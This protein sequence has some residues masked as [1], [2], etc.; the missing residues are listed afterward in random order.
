MILTKNEILA[1]IRSGGVTNA[2]ESLVDGITMDVRF[3]NEFLVEKPA[4]NPLVNL[5]EDG[6][7]SFHYLCVPDEEAFH[8][9]AR[10]FCMAKTMESFT[11]PNDMTGIFYLKS[12]HARAGLDHSQ[13]ILLKPGWSGN[14]VIELKNNL[15]W[16]HLGLKPGEPCGQVMFMKHAPTESYSGQY[17]NQTEFGANRDER[18]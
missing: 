9:I 15:K 6:E 1:F 2:D 11:M 17:Q 8:L 4:K 7:P 3:S 5:W 12:K 16:H 13:A 14:L 10:E 18:E